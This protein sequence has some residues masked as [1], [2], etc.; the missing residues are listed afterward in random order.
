MNGVQ[1]V[2]SALY[3]TVGDSSL[4]FEEYTTLFCRIE[5]MLNSRPLCEMSDDPA[6]AALALTPGHFLIGTSLH[7]L[8]EKPLDLSLSPHLRWTRVRQL[9]QHFWNRWSKEYLNTLLLRRKWTSSPRDLQVGDIVILKNVSTS[10][11]HWPL[12]RIVATHPGHD[13]VVRVVSVF[14]SSKVHTRAVN[15]VIPL[16][17]S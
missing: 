9:S 6:E 7:A 10:P 17:R 1:S 13:G 3:R 12:G 11:L 14:A 16:W 5:A 8:P 15:R 2:K 4:T